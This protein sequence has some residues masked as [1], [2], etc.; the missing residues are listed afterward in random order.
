VVTIKTAGNI[1]GGATW[2]VLRSLLCARPVKSVRCAISYVMQSGSSII[3]ND[4]SDLLAGETDVTVVFGDD[5][6]LSQSAALRSLMDLG[7]SLRL[8]ASEVHPP[9]DM[10]NRLLR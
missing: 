7:V 5:F 9:Q 2:G 3:R 10:A 8:Y 1:Y 6:R 4:L